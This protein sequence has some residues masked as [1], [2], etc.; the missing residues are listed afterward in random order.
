M[1]TL[2]L[3]L[4]KKLPKAELKMAAA[5]LPPTALVSMTAEETGGG[6]HPTTCKLEEWISANKLS[7]VIQLW[8][9]YPLRKT[10]STSPVSPKMYTTS[11]MAMGINIRVYP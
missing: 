6:I 10:S 9:T 1:H 7:F 11:V 4:T 3:E 5:S 2:V 8:C